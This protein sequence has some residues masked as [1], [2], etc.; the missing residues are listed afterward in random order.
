MFVWLLSL[1][2]DSCVCFVI[3]DLHAHLEGEAF[4]FFSLSMCSPPGL[5]VL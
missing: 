4:G 3:L 1:A 2:F 5:E